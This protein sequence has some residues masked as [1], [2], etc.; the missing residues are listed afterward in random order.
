M[1]EGEP[2]WVTVYPKIVPLTN[3]GLPSRT[4]IGTLRHTQPIYEDPNRVVGKREYMAGDSL[5]RIDWKSTASLGRLQVRQF[6]PSI[7]L[8]TVIVLNLNADEYELPSRSDDTE[9]AIVVAASMANW[10]AGQKQ[11]IGLI[12][13][14]IDPAATNHHVQYLPVRRGRGHLMRLLEML[15][16]AQTART[17]PMT[18]MLR[19]ES[20]RLAWGTTLILVTRQVDAALFDGMF[21][22]RRAGLNAVL[23][24]CGL[25]TDGGQAMRR[26]RQ[27]GFAAYRVESER[28]LITWRQSRWHTSPDLPSRT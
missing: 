16:R 15:A 1:Q 18:E 21:Q 11:P 26:A 9:L 25:A 24:L 12:T 20:P 3:V 27:F 14:G 13:N 22:A 10:I 2:D 4:P 23:I 19:R 28:D 7:S 6:Q 8:E 5:H 17:I